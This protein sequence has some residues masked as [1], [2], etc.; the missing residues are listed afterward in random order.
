MRSFL[1]PPRKSV[2]EHGNL[3]MSFLMAHEYVLL[4][5]GSSS[6][7]ISKNDKVMKYIFIDVVPTL[8]YLH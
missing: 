6:L 4:G 8:L 5:E 3:H 2:I 7:K 1:V